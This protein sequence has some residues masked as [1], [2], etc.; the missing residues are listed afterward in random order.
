MNE[1][2]LCYLTPQAMKA[3]YWLIEEYGLDKD[4]AIA[5]LEELV[6]ED[7]IYELPPQGGAV[8]LED[9]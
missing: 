8:A 9:V 6:P 1:K 5:V 7:Q 4:L 2:I 3:M